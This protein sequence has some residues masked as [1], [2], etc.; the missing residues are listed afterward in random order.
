MIELKDQL[1]KLESA[2]SLD[3]SDIQLAYEAD[4][5]RM[6]QIKKLLAMKNREIAIAQRKLDEIPSRPELVQYERRFTELYAQIALQ[7]DE[8]RKYYDTYN[9]LSETKKYLDKENSL[10]NS[11]A[12]YFQKSLTSKAKDYKPW[13]V[14][15][16]E[17]TVD[18]VKKS[19][20]HV[21]KKLNEEK[22]KKEDRN[23]IY[24][25]LVTIK[26]NYYRAVKELESEY[27]RNEELR[28]K[29]KQIL[30]ARKSE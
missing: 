15:N 18:A 29:A 11:V 21:E 8:T 20:E 5:K 30:E 16:M 2:S 24:Q 12:E 6:K 19:K 14:S 9:T 13:M 1:S 4:L 26:R 25:Q 23:G 17:K 22:E 3:S 27:K 7:F 10:L 28:K